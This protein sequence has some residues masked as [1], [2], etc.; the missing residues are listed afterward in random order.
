MRLARFAIV[1]C[2]LLTPPGCT[3]GGDDSEGGESSSSTNSTSSSGT[4]SESS[5]S[6]GTGGADPASCQAACMTASDCTDT[7][8][9]PD[10]DEDNFECNEG[11]CTYLGCL[12]DQDCDAAA[13]VC[14]D[15]G[16]GVQ[17][18]LRSCTTAAQCSLNTEGFDEDNFECREGGCVYTG[19]ASD[20]DCAALGSDATCVQVAGAPFA[21]CLETC[22]EAAD[23][24]QGTA[25]FD[26]DNYTCDDGVCMFTGCN[27]DQE[28]ASLG[29]GLVC[30]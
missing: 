8:A 2:S 4:G 3:T 26:D 13:E 7:G 16:L 12:S 1:A 5:E 29:A 11:V 19:C 30:R 6:E 9:G 10:L 20:A 17:R 14:A 25:A 22:A 24:D 23:C 21:G 15:D 27:D 28:C 18:C